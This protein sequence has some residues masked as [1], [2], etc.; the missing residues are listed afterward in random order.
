MATG[1]PAAFVVFCGFG[2]E[3]AGVDRGVAWEGLSLGVGVET[4]LGVGVETSLGIGVEVVVAGS[5]LEGVVL[6]TG[7]GAPPFML[8]PELEFKV[9][10]D[11]PDSPPE[12]K[13]GGVMEKTTPKPPTVPVAIK[14][15]RFIIYTE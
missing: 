10:I 13:L 9:P 5:T 15:A 11:D 6:C 1:V 7:V 14:I 2:L 3:V 4:S 8:G 12:P